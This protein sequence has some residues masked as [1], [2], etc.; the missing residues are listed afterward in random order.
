MS[1]KAVH[2]FVTPFVATASQPDEHRY[3]VVYRVARTATRYIGSRVEVGSHLAPSCVGQDPIDMMMSLLREHRWTPGHAQTLTVVVGK[4]APG[5][6]A[7]TWPLGADGAIRPTDLAVL[8]G[9]LL[10]VGR[11]PK[12]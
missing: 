9:W 6:P 5:A 11:R 2:P 4:A 10:G 12:T 1:T 3:S 8:R 7:I